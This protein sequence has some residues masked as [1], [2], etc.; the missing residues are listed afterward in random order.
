MIEIREVQKIYRRGDERVVAC[1]V[2]AL[3]V[4]AAEQIAIVG[5]S[6]CGKTTLMHIISGLLVP[7]R[8]SVRIDGQDI[9]ALSESRRDRYR[10]AHF[11]YV[12]QTFDLL[13]AYSALENVELSQYFA[14]GRM[15]RKVARGLLERVGL[16][17]RLG[18]R[19]NELSVGQQQRVAVAR[20]L[21]NKPHML[22][23]DE[24]TGSQDPESGKRTLALLRELASE[25][26][27]TMLLVT[28]DP[29][30]ARSMERVVEL[31]SLAG[32]LA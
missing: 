26:S 15:D 7:D 10:A 29:E 9:F 14:T 32:S 18:H 23:A 19:P 1:S 20:A 11:G 22:L 25:V 5:P 12:H 16:K 28:H 4:A 13:P 27:A 8:G 17:E 30:S 2:E 3:D 6:G 31:P 24:P 21:V